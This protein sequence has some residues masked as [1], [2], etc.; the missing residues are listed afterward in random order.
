VRLKKK[1]TS[2]ALENAS[3]SEK[4]HKIIGIARSSNTAGILV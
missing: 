3:G 4:I 2:N 1:S